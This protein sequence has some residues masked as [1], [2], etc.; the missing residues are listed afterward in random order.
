MG[1]EREHSGEPVASPDGQRDDLFRAWMDQASEGIFVSDLAGAYIE[2]NRRGCEMLGRTR[3]ETVGLNIR[4]IV[5]PDDQQQ[6]E[7]N[8]S[9]IERGRPF[10]TERRLL[11]RDGSSFVAEVST[12]RLEDGRFL[13]IARD[14]TARRA[15]EAATRRAEESFRALLDVLPDMVVVHRAGLIVYVNATA[16]RCCGYTK[17]DELLGT[18]VADLVHPDDRALVQARIGRMVATGA[19]EGLERERLM[20]RD[21][22]SFE[23]EVAALPLVFDGKPSFLAVAT[24]ATESARLRAQLIQSDRLASVG[25]LAAGVAHE[26]NNPLAYVLPNLERLVEGLATPSPDLGGLRDCVRGALDGV[27]RVQKIVRDLNVF[28]REAR[29]D[30]TAT[31]VNAAVDSA[32]LLADGELRFRAR[33][34]RELGARSPV[35]A[36]E[37]RLVQVLL[38]LVVNAAHAIPEGDAKAHEVRITTSDAPGEVRITVRDTGVG[39]AAENLPRLFD[40]FFTT[41]SPGMGSGLGLSV[42]HSIVASFGGRIEVESVRGAGSA[43]TVVLPAVATTPPPPPKEAYRPSSPQLPARPRLLL[44]DDERNVREVLQALLKAR[45]DVVAATSGQDALVKLTERADWHVV[46]CDLMMPEVS[47]MDIY[48]WVEQERPGLASRMV[49]MTGGA[50]T[51]RA[52][53]LLDRLPDR[54]IE[55]PFEFDEILALLDRL[56]EA[57]AVGA[58]G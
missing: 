1:D 10:L 29:D 43:F 55:K 39:I 21:G 41:K 46:V 16:A 49:F 22:T 50:F 14:V 54:W 57:Q 35:R 9:L 3:E 11:R 40:P 51:A 6:R 8:L 2:V 20:R 37:G 53:A 47:G 33:V 23:A 44:I 27:R 24:D 17:P 48:D 5:H 56:L 38:N 45:F 12:T 31:D 19:P 15:E 34:T 7:V 36:N 52:R 26:I 4:D 42:C 30:G 58:P 13:A 18:R 28:A 25:L 32:L